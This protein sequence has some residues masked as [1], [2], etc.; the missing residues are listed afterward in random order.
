MFKFNKHKE[1]FEKVASTVAGQEILEYL[2]SQYV[3]NNNTFS[4]SSTE[5]I[6]K[7]AQ[8]DLVLEILKLTQTTDPMRIITNE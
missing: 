5:I 4:D 6:Y 2:Y 3:L 8:K 7:S 1:A